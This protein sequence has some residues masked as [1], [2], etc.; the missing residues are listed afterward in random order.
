[1]QEKNSLAVQFKET[2]NNSKIVA[3]ALVLAGMGLALWAAYCPR[4]P[5]VAIGMLALVAGIM[6]LRPE[7]HVWEKCAWIIVLIAFTILEVHAIGVS[8]KNNEGVRDRQNKAFD[9]IAKKLTDSDHDNKQ[10]FD[11]TMGRFESVYDKTKQAADT[12]REAINT[13]TGGRGYCYIELAQSFSFSRDTGKLV[14][15]VQ[16]VK[17]K[18]LWR[19]SVR[20]LDYKAF[21]SDTRPISVDDMI[22][23][24]LL[25]R[26][27]TITQLGDLKLGPGPLFQ[28]MGFSTDEHADNDYILEFWAINGAW[29]EEM[30]YRFIDG[31]YLRAIRVVWLN[32]PPD[33]DTSKTTETILHEDVSPEYPR[34]KDGKVEWVGFH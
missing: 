7:M 2:W 17:A 33:F 1:M 15:M 12:A 26:D 23:G 9:D 27:A 5:G 4:S 20:V 21:K 6:S 14:P 24:G 18:V 19:V 28:N 22:S 25:T 3:W 34:G 16:V 29:K 8:D 32:F 10:H 31:K 13:I 30:H 11:E